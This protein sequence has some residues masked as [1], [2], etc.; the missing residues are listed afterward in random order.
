MVKHICVT[1]FQTNLEM[2]SKTNETDKKLD[3]KYKN[4]SPNV[5]FYINSQIFK[6]YKTIIN[7]QKVYYYNLFKQMKGIGY[8]ERATMFAD[9][10]Q[11]FVLYS[12]HFISNYINLSSYHNFI[13]SKKTPVHGNNDFDGLS[14]SMKFKRQCGVKYQSFLLMIQCLT[15]LNF[16]PFQENILIRIYSID[17]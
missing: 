8:F 9:I 6:N 12:T 7:F 1:L 4:G 16:S 3:M 17:I 2:K 11:S 15:L 13:F 10:K 5:F 14:F